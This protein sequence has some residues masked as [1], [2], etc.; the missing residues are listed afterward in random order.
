MG[1][2]L[3][4]SNLLL[5]GKSGSLLLLLSSFFPFLLYYSLLTFYRTS[6]TPRRCRGTKAPS[7]FG[8]APIYSVNILLHNRAQM[9]NITI[10]RV[11][12]DC[13]LTG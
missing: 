9:I 2:H 8:G 13:A 4:P 1:S 10:L 12:H 11:G 6:T 5:I 7:F 3:S